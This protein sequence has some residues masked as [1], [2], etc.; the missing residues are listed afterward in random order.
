MGNS[1]ICRHMHRSRLISSCLDVLVGQ[2]GE[3]FKN[4]SSVEL[5]G[6][7]ISYCAVVVFVSSCRYRSCLRGSVIRWMGFAVLLGGDC[8]GVNLC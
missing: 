5:H 1:L 6:M 3:G 4:D 7:M 2:D 8:D